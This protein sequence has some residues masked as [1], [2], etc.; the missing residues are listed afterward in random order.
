MS[1]TDGQTTYCG[2]T[3]LKWYFECQ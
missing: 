3:A 2:I 1:Q